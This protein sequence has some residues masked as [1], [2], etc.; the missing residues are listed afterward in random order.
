MEKCADGADIRKLFR[1][2]IGLFRR[3]VSG[4]G[5]EE[6]TAFARFQRE[7]GPKIGERVEYVS[8]GVLER[9]IEGNRSAKGLSA[10]DECFTIRF[11]SEEVL[12]RV[13]E[14]PMHEKWEVRR[15]IKKSPM[16]EEGVLLL[17]E[18]GPDKHIAKGLVIGIAKTVKEEDD[19]D[20]AGYLESPDG[21]ASVGK[22]EAANLE[23]TGLR[24]QDI[25]RCF[26]AMIAPFDVCRA[27][28]DFHPEVFGTS[29]DRCRRRRPI[30]SG[31]DISY[32]EKDTIVRRRTVACEEAFARFEVSVPERIEMRFERSV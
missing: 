9:A 13:E 5:E 28:A 19:V 32:K 11:E 3:K 2:A 16:V 1:K 8:F 23:V 29:K 18:F 4:I 15:I 26:Y 27:G 14:Y 24:H 31:V 22:G 10:S 6:R 12:R 20:G 25:D 17:F 21:C 7:S 30:C